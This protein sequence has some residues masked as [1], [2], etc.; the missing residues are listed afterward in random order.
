MMSA[1]TANAT[2]A[3]QDTLFQEKMKNEELGMLREQA[4]TQ[5]SQF[6]VGQ[7][8][9]E[10]IDTQTRKDLAITTALTG[11]E[12][13]GK[14]VVDLGLTKN[15]GLTNSAQLKVLKEAFPDYTINADNMKDF[16]RTIASDG[17]ISRFR[18]NPD[19]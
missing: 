4:R 7:A 9:K 10:A 19:N 5:R 15:Q 3:L 18:T 13:V 12:Q 11:A 1:V 8:D 14:T 2:K 6:N 16:V 17:D